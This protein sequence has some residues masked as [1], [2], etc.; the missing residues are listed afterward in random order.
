MTP[1]LIALLPFAVLLLWVLLA[2]PASPENDQP[3][4]HEPTV[5]ASGGIASG[6]MAHTRASKAAQLAKPNDGTLVK[7]VANYLAWPMPTFWILLL[8]GAVGAFVGSG[9]NAGGFIL[10]LLLNPILWVA[11]YAFFQI[12][13]IR[14]PH[15]R[16]N[17]P[18]GG[19]RDAA[20]GSTLACPSCRNHFTKPA[21]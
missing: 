7:P 4:L 21:A 3:P 6:G 1:I 9:G 16:R 5:N 2:I 10:A 11:G 20:V 17:V 8:L 18:L 12:G 19:S 14:C 15:C 13:R